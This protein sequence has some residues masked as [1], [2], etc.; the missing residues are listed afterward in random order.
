[1]IAALPMYD[2]PELRTATDALWSAIAAALGRMDVDEVPA[3][4]TRGR[5]AY[6]L[7]SD[8]ALLLAQ[9]CGYPLTHG[10]AGKVRP[11]AVP[12]YAAPGC[13]GPFYCSL[14]VVRTGSARTLGELRG[15]RAAFNTRDSQSGYAAL[16]AAAAPLARDGAFFGEAIETGAHAASIAAVREGRA[17][18]C[19]VDA[20]L[21]A[22][23][24][25]HRPQALD[26][27][28]VIAASPPCPGLP[29]VTAAAMSEATI[30]ALRVA[31]SDVANDP[32]L[33]GARAALLLDGFADLP[34]T[35]YDAVIAM[36]RDC[37]DHGYGDLA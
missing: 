20:V 22:L 12:C 33:A 6:G 36:E 16:R 35:A 5:E 17:D 19:A 1:M 21:H 25:R 15:A 2:L 29:Y 13:T 26:G 23:L 31:L 18:V 27:V 9:T 14:L 7:W 28:E 34:L 8:P 11:V 30:A 32:A 10:L 24:A 4:L 37:A 3:T